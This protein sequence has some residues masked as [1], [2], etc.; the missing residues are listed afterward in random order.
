LLERK[1]LGSAEDFIALAA[2]RSSLSGEA[3]GVRC[4]Q[5]APLPSAQWLR[6]ELRGLRGAAALTPRLEGGTR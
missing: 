3:Y 5:S 4:G 2:T 6:T 1:L